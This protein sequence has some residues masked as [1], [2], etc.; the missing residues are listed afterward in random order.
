[1]RILRR[2]EGSFVEMPQSI[3]GD[4]RD[5]GGNCDPYMGNA[6]LLAGKLGEGDRIFSVGNEVPVLRFSGSLARQARRQRERQAGSVW[7][8]SILFN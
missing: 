7:S 3:G 5:G 4:R 8:A 2:G 1:M 6:L